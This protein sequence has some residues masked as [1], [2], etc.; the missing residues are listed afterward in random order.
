MKFVF[1]IKQIRKWLYR[2]AVCYMLGFASA[3]DQ[4]TKSMEDN[5]F[6]TEQKIPDQKD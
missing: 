2:L 4:D 6:K 5:L 1:Y 3:M